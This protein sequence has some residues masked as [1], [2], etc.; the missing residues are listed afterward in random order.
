VLESYRQHIAEREA[1]GIPPLP[2][3][4]EQTETLVGL[5]QNAPAGEED[6]LVELLTHRVPAGVDDARSLSFGFSGSSN[7]APRHHAWRV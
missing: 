6:T 4:V 7:R 1:L 2:M 5:L 3:S